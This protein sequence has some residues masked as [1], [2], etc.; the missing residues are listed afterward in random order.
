MFTDA[1]IR[2]NFLSAIKKVIFFNVSLQKKGGIITR[3]YF[4]PYQPIS[5]HPRIH[6]LL[7]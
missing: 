4:I 5:G 2:I 6:H 3:P 1:N 7:L